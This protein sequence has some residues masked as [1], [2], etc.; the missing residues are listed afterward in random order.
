M[1]GIGKDR[2]IWEGKLSKENENGGN[3]QRHGQAGN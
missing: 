1:E 2:E 3:E